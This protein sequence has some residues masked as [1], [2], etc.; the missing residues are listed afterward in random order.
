MLV[1][2]PDEDHDSRLLDDGSRDM[3]G[4]ERDRDLTVGSKEG[5]DEAESNFSCSESLDRC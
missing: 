1:V 4:I 5:R 3:N 2:V